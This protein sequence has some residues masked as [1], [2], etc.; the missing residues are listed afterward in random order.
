MWIFHWLAHTGGHYLTEIFA[1]VLTWL[2]L[3]STSGT[4]LLNVHTE[5]ESIV[6]SKLVYHISA[7]VQK[8]DEITLIKQIE[9]PWFGL[10]MKLQKYNKMLTA[11]FWNSEDK[12]FVL[13]QLPGLKLVIKY[14]HWYLEYFGLIL[15][16]WEEVEALCSFFNSMIHKLQTP[17]LA[18]S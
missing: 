9:A 15:A 7:S 8:S 4:Y 17:V 11:K 14:S 2:A 12:W 6:V 13:L 3:L 16:P 18:W 10:R 5:Q 1:C